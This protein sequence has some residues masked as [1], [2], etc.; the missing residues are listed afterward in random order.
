[1]SCPYRDEPVYTRGE[2]PEPREHY[3]ELTDEQLAGL[4]VLLL[5]QDADRGRALRKL[6][7]IERVVS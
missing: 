7:A 3:A 2:C 6:E 1:M 5:M 4:Y